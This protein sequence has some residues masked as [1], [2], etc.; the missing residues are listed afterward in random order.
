MITVMS[1]LPQ[2]SPRLVESAQSRLGAMI[3]DLQHFVDLESPSRDLAALGRSAEFVGRCM[4]RLLGS[5]PRIIDGVL[6]PHVHWS[7]GGEPK[8][9]VLGHHDTVFPLGTVLARRFAVT[10]GF[11]TGPGVFDMKAGIIQALYGIALLEDASHVE[12]LLTADE[13][14]GSESSRALI[15]ERARACGRVL[16]LEPSADG[17]A[18]KTARKGTGTFRVHVHGRA[19]HAGL[20]PEKGCNALIE[21]AMQIARI[22]EFGRPE[23]GTTVTPTQAMAGTAEN[24]VPASATVTVDAR[25]EDPAEKERV[26]AL[27]RGLTPVLDGTSIVVEGGLT[28]PPMHASASATLFPIAEEVVRRLGLGTISGVGVGGGSDGNFTAAIGVP[29]LDGLGAVG[30]GAHA[31][32]E[33]VEVDTMPSRAALIAGLVATLSALS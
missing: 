14:I 5:F 28:R 19:A 12:I 4:E 24:V 10:D 9:L 6:G 13:E 16:V 23:L 11:A 2:V 29:T 18:L 3:E 32:H 20:E 22:S 21:A 25:V 27:M 8:V 17:G 26:E 31:D 30:G 15:E 7:G 1:E 33:F